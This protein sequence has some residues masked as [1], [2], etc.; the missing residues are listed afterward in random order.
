MSRLYLPSNVGVY[1]FEDDP[2][3]SRY[4]YAERFTC[5][6]ME[7]EGVNAEAYEGV[8]AH[9][10]NQLIEDTFPA[11]HPFR[12]K[13][14]V[15]DVTLGLGW[16]GSM[17]E[18]PEG[19]YYMREEPFSWGP[20]TEQSIKF[21]SGLHSLDPRGKYARVVHL[22]PSNPLYSRTDEDI[23]VVQLPRPPELLS[24]EPYT[25]CVVDVPDGAPPRLYPVRLLRQ[26]WSDKMPKRHGFEI[27]PTL[28]P[29]LH[30]LD[31]LGVNDIVV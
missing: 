21:F 15:R 6:G 25:S 28:H 1:S 17:W 31:A 29:F 12:Q 16:Y 26:G 4:T 23:R 13:V 14:R 9:R 30:F 10:I 5:G 18:L 3:L 8:A 20:N 19:E 7:G 11:D 2:E 22:H 24:R 27:V